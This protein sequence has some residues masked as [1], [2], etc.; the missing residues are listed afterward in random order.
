MEGKEQKRKLQIAKK[1]LTPEEW[2]L[3]EK[4]GCQTEELISVWTKKESYVKMTGKGLTE[5]LTTVDTLSNAFYQQ[6]LVDDAYMISVCTTLKDECAQVQDL[7][8][9]L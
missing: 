6:I 7:S 9:Y 1:I 5:N 2:K 4:A 8:E 3:W